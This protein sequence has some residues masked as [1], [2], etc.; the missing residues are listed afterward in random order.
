VRIA[1]YAPMKPPDH[2]VPSGDR[3][4]ARLLVAALESA[5]HR[6]CL[7]SR[8]RA[9]EGR[10]EA[11]IQARIAHRGEREAARLIEAYRAM[12]R[13]RRPHAWLTYHLYHKAPDFLGPRVADALSIPYLVAEASVAA[14]QADGPWRDGYRASL[15]ALRRADAVLAMTEDDRAGLAP[16]VARRRL[17]RLPP[18]LDP[19]PFVVPRDRTRLARRH[20]LD[21]GLPWLLAVAMMRPGDKLR[22]YVRLAR[23]LALVGDR[24]WRLLVVGDGPARVDVEGAFAD[25]GLDFVRYVGALQGAALPAYYAASDILVWPGVG[26]AY[27]MAYLEAQAGG[28]PVVCGDEPG[29][30]SV[31]RPGRSGLVA[32]AGDDA[33][34][35]AAVRRLLAD[36]CLRARLGRSARA[37]VRTHH[38]PGAAR[39][40]LD[41]AFRAAGLEP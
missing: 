19:E 23:A 27:G 37:Y 38:G 25:L 35:A 20:G 12:P 40:A 5:G 4:M 36:E 1:F 29:I 9:F 33:A 10:G 28:C 22:S 41:R 21:A 34:F 32:P 7:A 8:L 15:A 14:K 13:A 17:L 11:E 16:V 31:V 2:P 30:R 18:F 6:V 26:E 24:P 3:R 39:R